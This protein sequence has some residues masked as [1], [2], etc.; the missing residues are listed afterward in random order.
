MPINGITTIDAEPS[1]KDHRRPKPPPPFKNNTQTPRS[2]EIGEDSHN[3]TDGNI[4]V[5]C[6]IVER[7][8]NQ[9]CDTSY[10]RN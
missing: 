1:N 2:S 6:V 8:K 4:P 7:T 3:K 9:Q 5:G 10:K